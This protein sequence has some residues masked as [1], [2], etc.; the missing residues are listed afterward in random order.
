MIAKFFQFLDFG[1]PRHVVT[2]VTSV[3][4]IQAY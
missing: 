1:F 4:A 2:I 3:T